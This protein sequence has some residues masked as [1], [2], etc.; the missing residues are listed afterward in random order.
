[1]NSMKNCWPGH[2]ATDLENPPGS[3][4]GTMTLYNCQMLCDKT[5]NCQGISVSNN[6]TH[7]GYINCYRKGDIDLNACDDYIP[8]DTWTKD[9]MIHLFRFISLFFVFFSFLF[10]FEGVAWGA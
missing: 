10:S 6:E 4:A 8:Y 7:V 9:N 3:S 5:A 1:M 2:G